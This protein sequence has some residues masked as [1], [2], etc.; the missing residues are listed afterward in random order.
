[1]CYVPG[2]VAEAVTSLLKRL[3]QHSLHHRH[4]KKYI[5]IPIIPKYVQLVHPSKLY[6]IAPIELTRQNFRMVF[7]TCENSIREK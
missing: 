3:Q 4:H 7:S 6:V 5:M 1:M 2:R